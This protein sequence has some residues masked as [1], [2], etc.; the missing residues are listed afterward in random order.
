MKNRFNTL[1]RMPDIEPEKIAELIR[2][3]AQTHILPRY[4]IL[5][6]H[7]IGR[8]EGSANNLVTIADEETETAMSAAL[9]QMF[10]GSVFIG[11]EGVAKKTC[12]LE[13]LK[14]SE[15]VIWVMDPLD[16]THN[17]VH[18]GKE[19]CSMLACVIN[20]ETRFGWI[21]DILND[22]M[23]MVEKGAGARFGEEPLRVAAPKPYPDTK[24]FLGLHYYPKEIRPLLKSGTDE[25]GG[26]KTL[27]C[28]GHEY[29]RLASGTRDFAIYSRLFPW[30]H[31][32]GALMVQEA[33]GIV[34]TWDGKPYKPSDYYDRATNRFCGLII[35]SHDPLQT[36][37]QKNL[38]QKI[39]KEHR[40]SP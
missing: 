27:S 10:P 33:G 17:F 18:H 39:F 9:L 32:A 5:E 21:Y 36:R 31:L 22:K 15:G 14:K 6:D 26:I 25:F 37:L 38:A 19:F 16:G 20:G 12:S 40:P 34:N 28:A 8:K 1:I 23:A 2:E 29:L 4:K 3:S 7:E 30:D 13:S 24:G 35:A 11:E